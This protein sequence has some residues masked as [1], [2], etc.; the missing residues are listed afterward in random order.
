MARK[1]EEPKKNPWT[2]RLKRAKEYQEKNLKNHKRN[3]EL[4]FGR[5]GGNEQTLGQCAYG[6]GLVRSLIAGIYVQNPQMMVQAYDQSQSD[7]AK[8][9]NNIVQFDFDQMDMK[10]TGNLMIPDIFIDGYSAF[11]ER[12][13]T[14]K[15]LVNDPKDTEEGVDIRS[16]QYLGDRIPTQDI[17][18]DPTGTKLDL[19][20]HKC[21]F[22][23]FFPT[24]GE[25]KEDPFFNKS[26]PENLENFPEASIY[27]RDAATTTSKVPGQRESDPDFRTIAMWEVHDKVN[28]KIIYF[29]DAEKDHTWEMDWPYEL[30]LGGKLMFPVTLMHFFAS[31]EGFYP[32][33]LINVIANQLTVL[34]KLDWR[35]YKCCWTLNNKMGTWEGLMDSNQ[36]SALLSDHPDDDLITFKQEDL[37]KMIAGDMA[38]LPQS[39]DVIWPIKS[40]QMEHLQEAVQ[41]RQMLVQEITDVIGFSFSRTRRDASDPFCP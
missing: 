6:W 2:S 22:I 7:P 37:V 30:N 21:L 3:A 35:I 24:I 17:F 33:P 19:S 9:A 13:K 36:K 31:S 8:M 25:L 16:Q 23:R 28:K 18:F 38:G 34:N 10:G 1:K 12:V 15:R 39:E 4:L 27:N 14:D 40:P 11:I 26:L 20:D 32:I 41:A 29:P 5:S